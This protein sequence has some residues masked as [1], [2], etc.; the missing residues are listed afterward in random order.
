MTIE[1]RT[2]REEEA[3]GRLLKAKKEILSE[4]GRVVFEEAMVAAYA[5]NLIRTYSFQPEE[6]EEAMEKMRLAAAGLTG[7]DRELLAELVRT[8]R[9]AAASIDPRDIAP[10]PYYKAT[11][12]DFHWYYKML[13]GMVEEVLQE[14]S[15]A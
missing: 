8:A 14:E 15:T 13:A 10:V 9:A 6:C 12:G 11:Q 1:D 7:R 4:A 3:Y 5:A 2:T